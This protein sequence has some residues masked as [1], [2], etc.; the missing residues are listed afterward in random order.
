MQGIF[1]AFSALQ[2]LRAEDSLKPAATWTRRASAS[3]RL[4]EALMTPLNPDLRLPT[5][6]E[7]SLGEL[8]AGEHSPLFAAWRSL[9]P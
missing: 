5:E 7:G 6:A 3:F 9:F 4:I 1:L 8:E 2:A